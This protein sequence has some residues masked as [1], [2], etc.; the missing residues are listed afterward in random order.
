MEDESTA[1]FYGDI[2]EI[3]FEKNNFSRAL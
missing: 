2:A 3:L 1:K